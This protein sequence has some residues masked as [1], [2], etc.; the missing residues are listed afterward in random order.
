MFPSSISFYS[1][2]WPSRTVGSDASVTW[3]LFRKTACHFL[4]FHQ[5][6][7]PF[8]SLHV[9]SSANMPQTRN[10]NNEKRPIVT[11]EEYTLEGISDSEQES[12]P[13]PRKRTKTKAG[14]AQ[15]RTKTTKRGKAGKLSKLPDMPLDVLFEA[16]DSED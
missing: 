1:L 15:S 14:G 9:I 12:R 10:S 2:T 16:S 13:R 8:L 11:E 3:F 6:E 4:T 5:N 7:Q